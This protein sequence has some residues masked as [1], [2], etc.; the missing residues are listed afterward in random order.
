MTD[1]LDR[2]QPA[3]PAWHVRHRDHG[4]GRREPPPDHPAH[5]DDQPPDDDEPKLIDVR[6]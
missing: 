3:P 2:I 6:V 4:E 5:E 1:G